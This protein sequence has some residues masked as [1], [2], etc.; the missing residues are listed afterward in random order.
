MKALEFGDFRS[1]F[2]YAYRQTHSELFERNEFLSAPLL[3]PSFADIY[4][5]KTKLKS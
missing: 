4:I 5:Y 1:T 2:L 3:V